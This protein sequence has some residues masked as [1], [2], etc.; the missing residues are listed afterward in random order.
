[1]EI[2]EKD[3]MCGKVMRKLTMSDSLNTAERSHLAECESCMAEVIR[4]LD[5]ST[6]TESN[7]LGGVPGNANGE[8]YHTRREAQKALEQGRRIFQREFG[9]ALPEDR[10]W[11]RHS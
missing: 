6:A 1:M 9:I 2:P 8:L 5:R 7:G 10:K 3:Q 11:S 4:I